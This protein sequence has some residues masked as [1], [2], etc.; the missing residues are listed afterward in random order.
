MGT[1]SSERSASALSR[2]REKKRMY[3]CSEQESGSSDV[4]L[5]TPS[6]KGPYQGFEDDEELD[7]EDFIDCL[8]SFYQ[9]IT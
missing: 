7:T 8:S 4:D 1:S 6:E 5:Q 3:N 9:D 2:Q